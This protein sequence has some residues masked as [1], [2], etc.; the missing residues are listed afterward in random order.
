MPPLPE[1]FSGER[2]GRNQKWFLSSDLP[3][4]HTHAPPPP[5]AAATPSPHHHH[6][7]TAAPPSH[8]RGLLQPLP[9]TPSLRLRH[10]LHSGTAAAAQPLRGCLFL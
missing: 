2:S 7:T 9:S 3:D 5:P 6:V 10:H 1:N 8:H 4:P